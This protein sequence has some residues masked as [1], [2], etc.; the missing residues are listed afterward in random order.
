MMLKIKVFV[1]GVLEAALSTL[2]EFFGDMREAVAICPDCGRNR[3]TGAPCVTDP[4][5]FYEL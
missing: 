1:F 2:E 3:Y 4:M 5:R